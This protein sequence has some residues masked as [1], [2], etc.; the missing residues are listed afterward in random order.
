MG[1]K[2]MTLFECKADVRYRVVAERG[3]E[4]LTIVSEEEVDQKCFGSIPTQM[5]KHSRIQ[6]GIAKGAYVLL[7][8]F[9]LKIQGSDGSLYLIQPEKARQV[10]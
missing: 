9:T 4:A 3:S 2:G 10:G 1:R 6:R 8:G 5:I 7:V